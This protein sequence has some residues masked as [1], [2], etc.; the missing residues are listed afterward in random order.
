MIRSTHFQSGGFETVGSST[1]IIYMK[2]KPIISLRTLTL[3]KKLLLQHKG[4]KQKKKSQNLNGKTIKTKTNILQK[5]NTYVATKFCL[6]TDNNHNH[7]LPRILLPIIKHR[8]SFHTIQ[9]V[10]N[11]QHQWIKECIS[12]LINQ[13]TKQINK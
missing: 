10:C 3:L 2:Y 1:S 6:L 8:P 13:C 5:R 7:F 9:C 11:L 4:Y 12:Q